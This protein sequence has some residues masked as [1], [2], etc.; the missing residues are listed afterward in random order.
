MGDVDAAVAC[1][2]RSAPSPEAQPGAE[3][4]TGT[5]G[6]QHRGRRADAPRVMRPV[7]AAAA[8]GGEGHGI[9]FSLARRPHG[10]RLLRPRRGPGDHEGESRGPGVR[11]PHAQRPGGRRGPGAAAAAQAAAVTVDLSACDYLDSTFLGCL[12]GLHKQFGRKAAGEGAARKTSSPFAVAAPPERLAKLFGPTRLDRLIQAAQ[13]PPRVG[14]R[15]GA[16]GRSDR[17]RPTSATSPST[18]WSATAAWRKWKARSRRRSS[19]SPSS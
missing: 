8:K 17:R 9:P 4:E 3:G 7:R 5:P 11:H 2:D 10:R 6:C 16:A 14:G 12:L 1:Y 15:V 18:S 13:E 19:G